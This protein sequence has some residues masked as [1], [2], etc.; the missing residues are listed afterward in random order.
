MEKKDKLQE[1]RRKEIPN[2]IEKYQSLVNEIFTEVAKPFPNFK[3]IEVSEDGVVIKSIS[4]EEQFY[5]H[6]LMREKAVD[7]ADRM[8][9]KINNLELELNNPELFFALKNEEEKSTA[10]PTVTKRNWTKKKAEE[11]K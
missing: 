3:D 9:N 8:I 5:N 6:T 1:I 2:T 7:H 11:S 4:A 10:E